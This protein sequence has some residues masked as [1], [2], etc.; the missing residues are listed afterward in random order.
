MANPQQTEKAKIVRLE[1][2]L[3][4]RVTDDPDGVLAVLQTARRLLAEG[5]S[6]HKGDG[7]WEKSSKATRYTIIGALRHGVDLAHPR[8]RARAFNAAQHAVQG[9]LNADKTAELGMAHLPQPVIT[10]W[11]TN[12][13][14]TLEDALRIMD[15]A[16]KN[17]GKVN[18]AVNKAKGRK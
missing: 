7:W 2:R 4:A 1:R 10:R 17:Q 18:L 11:E 13:A 6:L 5:G 16:I 3:G 9:A 15:A 8:D 12:P 14:S